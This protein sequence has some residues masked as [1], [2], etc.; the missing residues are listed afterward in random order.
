MKKYIAKLFLKNGT[1]VDGKIKKWSK[2]KV[3]LKTTKG[4]LII[5]NPSENIMMILIED[6]IKKPKTKSVSKSISPPLPIEINQLWS[7]NN[8]KWIV[9]DIVNNYIKL[10]NVLDS[11]VIYPDSTELNS[12]NGWILEAA[13]ATT[14]QSK[15]SIEYESENLDQELKG[16]PAPEIPYEPDVS[17]KAK[18]LT[19]LHRLKKQQETEQVINKLKNFVPSQNNLKV[20]YDLPFTKKPSTPNGS[21]TKN[22]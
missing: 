10:E 18:K 17:L 5:F 13:Q 4:K 1:T 14:I 7:Y 2:K 19:E 11:E 21:T 20:K 3:V 12:S 16:I 8:T 6:K 9:T 15:S 22:S